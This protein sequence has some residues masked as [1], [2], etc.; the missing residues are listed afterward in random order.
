MSMYMSKR[1]KSKYE[2][3]MRNFRKS[4]E[5]GTDG[6]NMKKNM[7]ARKWRRVENGTH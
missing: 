5:L 4:T 3:T 2:R 1:K 6:V 7:G